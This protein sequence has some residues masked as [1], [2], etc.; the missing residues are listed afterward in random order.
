MAKTRFEWDA[1]KNL[2]NERKH[3]VDFETAARAFADPLA[4][5]EQ[6]RIE[7]GEA[8]WW[9]LG[10]VEWRLLLFVAH[11]V[12]EETNEGDEAIEVIRIISARKADRKERRRYEDEI[13]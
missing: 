1:N 6:D 13:R 11:T 12:W 9:T 5:S 7:D 2:A 4:L 3:G 10:L 8:R